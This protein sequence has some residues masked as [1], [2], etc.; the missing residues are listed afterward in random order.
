MGRPVICE[1]NMGLS[2]RYLRTCYTNSAKVESISLYESNMHVDN[3]TPGDFGHSIG[4]GQVKG[5][6]MSFNVQC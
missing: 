3:F 2:S 4:H 1:D 6:H 5:S